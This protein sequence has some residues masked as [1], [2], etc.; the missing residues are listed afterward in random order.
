MKKYLSL[1]FSIYFLSLNAQNSHTIMAVAGGITFSPDTLTITIGDTISFNIG[2]TH[3]AVE[4]SDSTW[5]AN[6]TASNGGFNIP[7]GGGA[8]IPTTVQAYYYVCQPHVTMGMKGVIIANAL[9]IYGCTDSTACNYDSLAT[10]DDSSCVYPTSTTTTITACDS[11][12]WLVNGVTYTTSVSD[13]VIGINAAGCTETTIL[14]ITINVGGGCTDSLASNYD[15]LA[16]CDNGSCIYPLPYTPIFFSEYGEGSSSNKYFEVY[17]PTNDT[18]DLLNYAFARV[19]NSPSNGIGI[20]E[21]WVDFDS[22]AVILPND[23][24]V[25]AHPSADSF[26]LAEADMSYGSL[27]NGNDGFALVYGAEPPSPVIP[28]SGGYFIVDWLGDWNGDPGSGWDVAGVNNAT[29]NH[30]LIRKC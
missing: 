11:Y 26:I 23:V 8:F 1:L 12:T 16:T 15:S 19:S 2:S 13:T 25:V 7:F 10:I 3:N 30:T 4:V 18:I 27:S 6:G 17:N 21:Y 20:Y 28:D 24:Y 5:I 29:A 22:G 14:N 9:P